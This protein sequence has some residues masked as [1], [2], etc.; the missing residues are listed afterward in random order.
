MTTGSAFSGIPEWLLAAEASGQFRIRRIRDAATDRS[1]DVVVDGRSLLSFAS[2]DYLGLANH[3]EVVAAA[4][5][6]IDQYGAGASA[7]AALGGHTRL[8][9]ALEAEL[10]DWLQW[11]RSLL[12]SSGYLANL[13]VQS[14]LVGR[15]MTV[16]HDRLN[17]ASLLDGTVLARARVR[18][19]RHLDAD[20]LARQ[21]SSRPAALV[22]TESVFSMDG[23][24][25]PVRDLAHHCQLA[26]T[27][28]LVDEAHALGVC[29]PAGRGVVAQAGLDVAAVPLLIGTLGKS[30]GSQGAFVAGPESVIEYLAQRSRPAIY[31]T[32]LAPA[33][34]AAARAALALVRRDPSRQTH[35]AR[36]AGRFQSLA[37]SAGLNCLASTTAIQALLVGEVEATLRLS[38]GLTERG[39]WVPPIRPPTVPAG[40]ARLR[41][42]L[43]AAHRLEQVEDLVAALVELGAAEFGSVGMKPVPA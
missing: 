38:A 9:A 17:H 26:G 30:L 19:Y 13:G 23:D 42:S 37:Q 35:L 34:V 4:H 21:V 31:T 36:L 11:P 33:A 25:A 16:L 18:R 3:P 40:R 28:L 27:P 32:A 24:I 1:P 22:A 29:G 6:A 43:T 14:T 2:N 7:S 39:F 5:A 8:H 41:I 10:A 15:G 12:Y 20:D